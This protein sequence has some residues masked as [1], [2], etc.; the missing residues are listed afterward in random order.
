MSRRSSRTDAPVLGGL[1]LHGVGSLFC[2]LTCHRLTRVATC[3]V[4]GGLRKRKRELAAPALEIVE[5]I[6]D[7]R[8]PEELQLV[9]CW[10]GSC[11]SGEQQR[12]GRA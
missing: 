6:L 5:A 8:Q 1:L 9:I 3:F 7:G 10:M 2:R 12:M 4:L 11:W